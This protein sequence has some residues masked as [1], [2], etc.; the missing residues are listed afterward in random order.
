MTLFYVITGSI[1]GQDRYV[2][3]AALVVIGWGCW[4]APTGSQKRWSVLRWMF[5]IALAGITSYLMVAYLFPIGQ[6]YMLG[7]RDG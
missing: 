4:L 2:L 3:S 7:I 1:R 5:V 6:P